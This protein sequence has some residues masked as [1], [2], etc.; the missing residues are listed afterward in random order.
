MVS[1]TFLSQVQS[2]SLY[3][4]SSKYKKLLTTAFCTASCLCCRGEK[5]R[6]K[7]QLS[8]QGAFPRPCRFPARILIQRI[9]SWVHHKT[10]MK[11]KSARQSMHYFVHLS[12]TQPVHSCV[13]AGTKPACH[14]FGWAVNGPVPESIFHCCLSHTPVLVPFKPFSPAAVKRHLANCSDKGL[15]KGITIY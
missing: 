10:L 4:S 3:A 14:S 13:T 12:L 11:H 9:K 8:L 1:I 7:L 6:D 2:W 15:S 5:R